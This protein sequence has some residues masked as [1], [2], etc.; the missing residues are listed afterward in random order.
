MILITIFPRTYLSA[1]LLFAAMI[2]AAS[3]TAAQNDDRPKLVVQ[4]GHTDGLSDVAYSPDGKVVATAGR[5]GMVKLWETKSF[6]LLNT[7]EGHSEGSPELSFS[8]DGRLL[9][10]C[11]YEE[12]KIWQVQTG[13]LVHDLRNETK[14]VCSM[15]FSPDGRLLA[16]IGDND[17]SN[18]IKIWDVRGGNLVKEFGGNRKVYSLGFAL[19]GKALVT[20]NGKKITVWTIPDGKLLRSFDAPDGASQLVVHPNGRTFVTVGSNDSYD[21]IVTLWDV[22]RGALRTLFTFSDEAARLQDIDF[23]LDGKILAVGYWANS[24]ELIPRLEL[25]NPD[26]GRLI[27]AIQTE[28]STGVSSLAISP[29][30]K[31]IV[32]A[33]TNPGLDGG[34]PIA[35]VWDANSGE[36]LDNT[37]RGMDEA[38]ALAVSRDGKLIARSA[39]RSLQLIDVE[40][41]ELVRILPWQT[42]D[43]PAGMAFSPD[44]KRLASVSPKGGG[45]VWSTSDGSLIKTFG[46]AADGLLSVAYGADGRQLAAGGAG[47]VVQLIDAQSGSTVKR[48]SVPRLGA[49]AASA[50]F[51]PAGFAQEQKPGVYI[52]SLAFSPDGRTLAV[53]GNISSPQG[54][55]AFGATRPG[56]PAAYAV[57]LAGFQRREPNYAGLSLWDV[58]RGALIRTLGEESPSVNSILF[59][60]D[61]DTFFVGYDDKLIR[62]WSVKSEEP[63]ITRRDGAYGTTLALSPD[64]KLLASQS[65]DGTIRLRSASDGSVIREFSGHSNGASSFVFARGGRTLVSVGGDA[66]TK[67]WSV[68]DG[69]LLVTYVSKTCSEK[70]AEWISFSPDGYY[71]ASKGGAWGVRWRVGNVLFDESQYRQYH[72]PDL[73]A[74]RLGDSPQASPAAAVAATSSNGAGLAP[75]VER[76][77]WERMPAKQ[78]HA[79]IIGN[80]D[81]RHLGPLRTSI[82]DAKAVEKVLREEYGF[83]TKL[84][85]DA[86]RAQIMAAINEYRIELGDDSNLLIYYAGHGDYVE[87]MRKAYWHPVDAKST[88]STNWISADDISDNLR[89][90]DAKHVLIISDSC[91]SGQLVKGQI[92]STSSVTESESKLRDSMY[93]TSRTIITSGTNEPVIDDEGNGHSIFANAFLSALK[94]VEPN[95]FTAYSLFYK[96]ML[97]KGSAAKRQTPQYDRLFSAGHLDGDFVFFRKRVH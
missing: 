10:T 18:P 37:L 81:Y 36:H 59:G 87:K 6:Y 85:L 14:G 88:D 54:N 69:R 62:V 95:V 84:L 11:E 68:E 39:W 23:S 92:V 96:E 78:F 53:G 34:S 91:Y 75:E 44:G 35:F 17:H 77:L 55:V 43:E 70:C 94:D 71:D 80:N 48:L 22:E 19:D 72:R 3:G 76:R 56:H 42:E 28:W 57:V 89:G 64:G 32:T 31:R 13:R 50:S 8:P 74:A 61:G 51:M 46:A 16:S 4:N 63:L 73:I 1:L 47:N 21:S 45:K 30:G 9:A 12:L 83:K 79:L 90:M 67:F 27:R 52:T 25:R 5:D 93:S 41:A 82:N 33:C 49:P 2:F 29:D 86:D 20:D 58:R 60:S 97:P 66:T 40:R 26:T 7:L 38:G 24:N 15:S 65:E